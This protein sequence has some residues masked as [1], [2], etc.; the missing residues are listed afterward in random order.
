MKPGFI[1]GRVES[2]AYVP[3]LVL[4]G[5]M[6]HTAMSVAFDVILWFYDFFTFIGCF[7]G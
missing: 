2:S 6:M 4:G 7:Q 5:S 1:W 3:R